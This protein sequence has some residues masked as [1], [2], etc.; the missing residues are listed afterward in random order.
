MLDHACNRARV[1]L[2]AL[3]GLVHRSTQRKVTSRMG[4]RSGRTWR[5]PRKVGVGSRIFD[6]TT[7]GEGRC[8]AV[9]NSGCFVGCLVKADS[10]GSE[11]FLYHGAVFSVKL[12]LAVLKKSKVLFVIAHFLFTPIPLN[13][14]YPLRKSNVT[15]RNIQQ[16]PVVER[17]VG[18]A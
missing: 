7:C 3:S 6:L 13:R 11:A 15:L 18:R 2:E 14:P 4:R 17:G 5:M 12:V 10:M 1:A 16:T 9:Y 8:I